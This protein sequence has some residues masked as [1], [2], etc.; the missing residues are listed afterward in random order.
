MKISAVHEN[1]FRSGSLATFH[2][3]RN[4]APFHTR[5]GWT[6]G[7]GRPMPFEWPAKQLAI[8]RAFTFILRWLHVLRCLAFSAIRFRP[9]A[10]PGTLLRPPS[11]HTGDSCTVSLTMASNVHFLRPRSLVDIHSTTRVIDTP[12][13]NRHSTRTVVH[14]LHRRPSHC[15]PASSSLRHPGFP[16]LPAP[17]AFRLSHH[18]WQ[19]STL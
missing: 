14:G 7:W 4:F 2:Y 13:R 3:R 16:S 10:C 19:P 15:R 17:V 11:S 9:V 8:L 1:P 12:P 6:F 5:C 18:G